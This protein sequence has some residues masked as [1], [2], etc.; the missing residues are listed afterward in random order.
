MAFNNRKSWRLRFID[1]DNS[2]VIQESE[3]EVIG[4]FAIRAPKGNQRPTY[5]PKAN[6]GAIDALVGLGSA[7]WPDIIEA[8]K[9]NEEYPCYISA[10]PGSSKSYP[11]HLGGFYFTKNGIYKFYNV[12]SK[13]D[14]DNGTG[15]AFQVKVVPGKEDEFNPDFANR[16]TTITV[17]GPK[18]TDYTPADGA[19]GAGLIELKNADTWSISFKKPASLKVTAI[20]YDTMRYGLVSAA[21]TDTTYWGDNEGLWTF[22]GNTATLLDFGRYYS[23]EEKGAEAEEGDEDGGFNALRDWIGE[24][25]YN[26]VK[27]R[28]EALVELLVNGFYLGEEENASIAFGIQNNFSYQVDI[29]E[30]VLALWMQK[31][32]TEA[33]TTVEISMVGYDKYYYEKLLNYAPFEK[34]E[35]EGRVIGYKIKQDNLSDE[36]KEALELKMYDNEYLGF[37]NPEKPEKG[38]VYI[39]KLNCDDESDL[40]YEV[41]GDLNTKY[42]AFQNNLA[43]VK[44][45]SIYHKFYKPVAGDDV[46]HILTL[47]EENEIWGTVD[48]PLNYEVGITEGTAVPVNPLF[49]QITVACSEEVYAGQTTSGGEFTGSLDEQ[50]VNTFGNPCYFPDVIS[51]DDFSFLEVRVF[52]KFGDNPGDLDE[53]GF[54]NYKRIIDPYDIDKD[55]VSPT[56]KKFTVEGDRYCTLVMEQNLALG[57]LGGDWNDNYKQLLADSLEEATLGEYDDAY[58]FVECT[59]QEVFKPAL[60]KICQAQQNAAVISPKLIEPNAKGIVTDTIASK[61]VVT[62]RTNEGCNALYAGEFEVKDEVTKKKYWRKP[63]GAV[64]QMLARIYDK[65]YGGSAPA[66]ANENGIGGQL[67]VKAIRSRWQLDPDAEKTLDKKGVNPIVMTTQEGVMIISQK[68]NRDPNLLSDW[69]YIGHA[70]SFLL[71][72]REIRDKVMRP[73]VM[74]P[75]NSYYMNKR[76]EQTDAILGKRLAGENPVWTKAT[77]EIESV[78]NQYTKS[79]RDFVIEVA[80]TCTPFSETVTLRLVHNLAE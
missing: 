50:G 2:Y 35:K 42:L 20:D 73:Q 34:Y 39:G 64:A 29:A 54:W 71:V 8:R 17:S 69:S 59:G 6:G 23:A 57:R 51:D 56:K 38:I 27:D 37:Y 11:S 26:V 10:A 53:T 13:A 78:N 5:F 44:V 63:I 77:C 66:W 60:A 33:E 32:P 21:G 70:L 52:K 1:I 31:C 36:E 61:L 49:N 74:K 75:I 7:N 48:G 15:N 41:N 25:A 30:D 3:D 18:L 22:V 28:P 16:L 67:D 72:R 40:Y 24:D 14:I 76:Q 45:D 55:G 12:E 79:Q 58:L 80:I 19:V 47:E 9:F 65:R 46:R 62:D 68:T 43:G 4:Y